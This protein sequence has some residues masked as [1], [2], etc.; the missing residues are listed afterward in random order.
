MAIPEAIR[1]NFNTLVKAVKQGDIALLECRDR[2]TGESAYAICAINRIRQADRE[3]EIEMVPFGV[4]FSSDPYEILIPASDP[5]FD[6]L[7]DK[8]KMKAGGKRRRQGRENRP[9]G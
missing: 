5:E 6:E 7:S 3:P 9:Q 2:D 1:T 4:M 8:K